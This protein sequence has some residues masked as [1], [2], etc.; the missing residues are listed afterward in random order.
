MLEIKLNLLSPNKKK[1]AQQLVCFMFSKYILEIAIFMCSLIATSLIWSWLILQNGYSEIAASSALVNREYTSHNMD[2]R[3]INK[4]SRN[5]NEASRA[6]MAVTPK[7]LEIIEKLPGDIKLNSLHI[8]RREQT[9]SI[10]G[11]AKTRTDLLDYQKKLSEVS[12]INKV[13]APNSKLFQK[14]NISFQFKTK[15]KDFLPI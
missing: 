2:I 4:I 12:W 7:L 5:I 3:K 11:V 13:E 8:D 9:L 6:Y 15:L 10:S 14:E 1:R